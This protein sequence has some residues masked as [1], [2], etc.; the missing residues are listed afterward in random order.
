MKATTLGM[1]LFFLTTVM[2]FAKARD[3]KQELAVLRHEKQLN[4]TICMRHSE[5]LL[6]HVLINLQL[7]AICDK[8][9][10]S[11]NEK[12]KNKEL[13]NLMRKVN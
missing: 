3:L 2:Y 7:N 4:D 1:V 11:R 9:Q 12:R 13:L 5:K 8:F 10:S 6:N